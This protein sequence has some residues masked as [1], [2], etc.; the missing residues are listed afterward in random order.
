MKN[1][2]WRGFQNDKY[3][4][5]EEPLYGCGDDFDDDFDDDYEL[6]PDDEFEDF[7]DPYRDEDSELEEALDVPGPEELETFDEFDDLE[8]D[9]NAFEE[10]D[11]DI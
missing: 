3:N 2:I 1:P 8:S 6:L 9:E 7:C 11:T 4:E 10:D 5:D